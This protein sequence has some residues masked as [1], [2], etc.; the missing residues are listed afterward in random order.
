[1]PASTT[2]EQPITSTGMPQAPPEESL[3][4]RLERL[5][6]A[7]Q[8]G[9]RARP[10]DRRKSPEVDIL[11]ATERLLSE[12]SLHDLSVRHIL[13]G[14][15]V[16]RTTFYFYFSSKFTVVTALAAGVMSEIYERMVPFVQRARD[17]P[18]QVALHRSLKAGCEVWTKHRIV[19]RA[20]HENWHA[21]PEIREVWLAI[22]D[23]FA[24][25]I[26]AE[27]EAERAAGLAP[28]GADARQLAS[29]L[30]WATAECMYVAG[31]RVDEGLPDEETIFDPLLAMWLG[32]FYRG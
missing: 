25:A 28:A 18:P 13:D 29:A 17:E 20:L 24:A 6:S 1:M 22:T 27:I 12:G 8:T 32:A 23:G 30:V 4:E 2:P 21:V 16:S 9:D 14:A 7:A 11:E 26:A 19:M 31:L 3:P 5:M 10:H 15:G